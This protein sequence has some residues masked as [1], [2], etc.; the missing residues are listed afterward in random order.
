M[1]TETDVQSVVHN[2]EEGKWKKW[3][4]LVLILSVTAFVSCLFLIGQFRGLGHAKAMDQAQVAREI[5]RGH[6]F[7]T[8]FIRPV[9]LTQLLQ[10]KG[11]IP[12]DQFPDT[13]NA[14]LNPWVNSF[15]LRLTRSSWQ[16]TT[17]EIVYASDRL[18]AGVAILFFILSVAVN[19]FT[20]RRLFDSRLATFAA[21]AMLISEPFWQYAISGLPQ[22]LMLLIFSGALYMMVR[23]MQVYE[24]G[25]SPTLWLILTAILFGLL[26]L[27]HGL[28]IWIFLGALAFVA[29][30]FRPL[31]K[32]AL[33]MAAVLA[34]CY[35]PWM[36]RNYSVCGSAFGLAPYTMFFQL[37]G[38]ES[39]VMRSSD[40]D[41]SGLTPISFRN[42]IQNQTAEQLSNLYGNLGYSFA[43][44]TFFITLLHLYKRPVIAK[45]RWGVLL[46]F[47]FAML[48]MSIFGCS[49]EEPLKSNNLTILFVPVMS[50]YGLAYILYLWSQWEVHIRI[51]NIAFVI[52]IYTILGL[53]LIRDL[54]SPPANRVQWPPYIP[55]YISILNTWTNENEIIASD[56]PWGVA[57]YADRKSLWLP[58]TINDFI[59]FND[60]N[61]LG[62]RLIGLYL[63]PVSGNKSFI[64]GIVKGEYKEWAQFIMR[65]VSSKDFPLRAVTGLPVDNECVFYSDRDRWSGRT[66]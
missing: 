61:R 35:A 58:T 12:A 25:G 5:A 34:L 51:F 64:S 33:I 62:N 43:A 38:S 52:L 20:A 7:T 59:A 39:D 2:L 37:R 3:V 44:L 55:P 50:F 26:A 21:C 30:H 14:P 60:Y 28:T 66:E 53:P 23:A 47:L 32:H 4:Q 65:T 1:A 63:T 56:M 36:V 6:G 49:D 18:I 57:W 11:N 13:Y 41:F 42:K 22:M 40:L 9:A 8:K 46:M 27:T 24:E 15:F 17:K 29:I 16:M 31:G 54:L 45:F 19:F 10:N 48:G